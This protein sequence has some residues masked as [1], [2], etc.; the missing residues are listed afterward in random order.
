MK[1]YLWKAIFRLKIVVIRAEFTLLKHCF[2]INIK[3][4]HFLRIDSFRSKKRGG[5]KTHTINKRMEIFKISR[6][7][8]S[9][10]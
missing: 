10:I 4:K 2:K 8:Y 7:R 5:F 1:K 3:E 6:W 9:S